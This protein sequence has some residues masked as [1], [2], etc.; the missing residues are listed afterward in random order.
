MDQP[1][2][3]WPNNINQHQQH[4]YIGKRLSSII[5]TWPQHQW[6]YHG[7]SIQWFIS[8]ITFMTRGKYE[9]SKPV[10]VTNERLQHHHHY[11][12][13]K[14]DFYHHL[15]D[16][17]QVR[18][19]LSG[20]G[21]KVASLLFASHRERFERRRGWWCCFLWRRK[22]IW[23]AESFPSG[24]SYI[25]RL[26]WGITAHSYLSYSFDKSITWTGAP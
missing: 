19:I 16:Q 1:Q 17:R 2:P 14:P 10:S 21:D 7:K 25:N 4:H 12:W 5:F 15:H 9:S 22:S 24:K 13:E 26:S 3:E 11:H 8:A 20:V 23:D 18:L 6:Y